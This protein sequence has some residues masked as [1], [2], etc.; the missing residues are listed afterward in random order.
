MRDPLNKRLPR[1]FIH[2]FGKYMVIFILMVFSI[3]LEGGYIVGDGSM[4]KAYNESFEKYTIEDGNFTTR[5]KMNLAQKKIV[6][7]Y[8]I[9]T[10][11]N[12]Y[13]ELKD[14]A[15]R[16]Y[17]LYKNRDEVDRI[18]IFEGKIPDSKYEIALDR[19]FCVNNGFS[20][21]D[22]IV[23]DG[24][25][26]LL[27]GIVALS[28]YSSLFSSSGDIMFDSVSFTVGIVSDEKF[29]EYDKV[30][31]NYAYL[32]ENAP[33]DEKEEKEMA[34]D[35]S[36][37]LS[38]E[39]VL[40]SFTPRYLNPA[41]TFTGEDM[42]S[43]KAMMSVLFYIII[44]IMAFVFSLT[45]ATTIRKEMSVIGTLLASGYTKRELIIHYMKLPL[46]V[47]LVSA[48]IGNI[49]GYTW[50]KD[51]VVGLYY[52]SYSLPTYKTVWSP[53]AF[54]STTLVPIAMM[55]VID[56]LV[57]NWKLRMPI[58]NFLRKQN[59]SSRNRRAFPLSRRI[60]FIDRFRTRIF[61]KNIPSYL[62]MLVGIL[63]ANLLILFGLDF[64]KIID[65][66]EAE[67]LSNPLA[68]YITMLN[69]PPSMNRDDH[70]LENSFEMLEF[71]NEV[72][73]DNDTAEKISAYSLRTIA[74]LEMGYN[75]ESVTVYGIEK[76]S[77]FIDLDLDDHE[78]Y[79]SSA[80]ADKFLLEE[81][82]HIILKEEYED[83]YYDLQIDGTYDYLG[84]LCIFMSREDLN[85]AFD[86]DK[87]TF[88]GYFSKTPIE[89][90]DKKYIGTVIDDV[91]LTKLSRQLKISFGG[92]MDMVVVFAVVIYVVLIY[93]LS[94]MMIESSAQS[95]SMSK[96]MGYTNG[97]IASLYIVTTTIVF[98]ILLI[99]SLP[100]EIKGLIAIFRYMLTVKMSGWFPLTIGREVLIKTVAIAVVS[101]TLVTLFELR[102]IAK[103]PMDQ[104]LKNME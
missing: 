38:K 96:I 30:L 75:G 10:Y 80:Y 26:Y 87:E 21:N 20:L 56:L 100:L 17:R 61:M 29:S 54:V 65:E 40:D 84:G 98:L 91:A 97:E 12:F 85:K 13:V 92:M 63:F 15:G 59:T 4:I 47:T 57:L 37:D 79:I 78:I 11:E 35:L 5:K 1:E 34:E 72:Q 103:V 66:Y 101:Y 60:P 27:C 71:Y 95:I 102:R 73:T 90:I 43:D 74:D 70:R 88:V 42:G 14:D 67:M 104:A 23:I 55:I 41:I 6:E 22:K 49:V 77:D 81:G 9:R 93:I 86:M 8:G 53:E 16:T 3:G 46:L 76:D 52:N 2:E 64:P 45:A 31:Y 39:V 28:D 19:A 58:L 62:L 82:D 94:K 18:D 7:T 51:M 36:K 89:D 68:P 48:I 99:G 24:E 32:Y 44:A 33:T 25:E 69:M 83:T 50:M